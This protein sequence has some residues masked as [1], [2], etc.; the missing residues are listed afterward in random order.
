MLRIHKQIWCHFLI[1]R[2][3]HL[4]DLWT[5]TLFCGSLTAVLQQQGVQLLAALD[6]D[7]QWTALYPQTEVDGDTLEV[8]AVAGQGLYV[9]VIHEADA[10]EVD[11][12]QVGRVTLD[13]ADV[14][15]LIY[16]LLLL[17]TQFKGPWGVKGKHR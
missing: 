3:V 11:D 7:P 12:A 14:D 4:P 6:D 16:L 8:D 17:I 5:L 1:W 15:H 13:L 10:V 2:L 9:R